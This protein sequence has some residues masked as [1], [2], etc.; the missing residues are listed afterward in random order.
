M[1]IHPAR[2]SEERTCRIAGSAHSAPPLS[3]DGR[4]AKSA[5]RREKTSTGRTRHASRAQKSGRRRARVVTS[6]FVGV[7]RISPRRLA[8]RRRGAALTSTC[9]ED[10]G[11]DARDLLLTRQPL[12]RDASTPPLPRGV[13]PPRHGLQASLGSIERDENLTGTRSLFFAPRADRART[14]RRASPALHASTRRTSKIRF[15]PRGS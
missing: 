12:V 14:P 7:L 13:P 5:S 2:E 8:D 10:T 6:I 4:A 3:A 1:S 15:L 11:E 9:E